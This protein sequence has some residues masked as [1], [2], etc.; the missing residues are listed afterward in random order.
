MGDAISILLAVEAVLY[1]TDSDCDAWREMYEDLPNRLVKVTVSDRGV[2]ETTDAER[3]C[4]KSGA[5]DSLER[6]T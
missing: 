6:I 1:L 5:R 4:V 3:V 2:F